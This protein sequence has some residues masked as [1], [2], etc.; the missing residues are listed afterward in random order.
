[1]Y[2]YFYMAYIFDESVILGSDGVLLLKTLVQPRPQRYV[3]D[4]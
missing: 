3:T 1:M 4:K 2:T